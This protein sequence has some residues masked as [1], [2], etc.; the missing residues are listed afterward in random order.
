VAA[1]KRPLQIRVVAQPRR[2]AG[3]ATLSGP[4]QTGRETVFMV[5]AIVGPAQ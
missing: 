2:W 5:G 4:P 1:A 3:A